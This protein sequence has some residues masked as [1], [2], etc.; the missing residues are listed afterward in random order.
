MLPYGPSI[1]A[2]RGETVFKNEKVTTLRI[3]AALIA[4]SAL[5]ASAAGIAFPGIYKPILPDHEVPFAF[6]QDI[7]SI[8]SAV[9]LLFTGTKRSA[10]FDIFRIGIIGYLFYAYGM[11]TI[12]MLYNY[13]YFLYLAVFGLSIFYFIIA[14]TGI[15]YDSLKFGMPSLL[16]IVIAI[17]CAFIAVFFA[18][19]WVVELSHIIQTNSR[20]AVFSFTPS[21]YILDLCFVLP[22]CAL[23][24]IFLFRKKVLGFALGGAISI[25]GFTLM[26]SVAAGFF[27]QPLFQQNMSVSD[28]VEFSA[29][30]AVFLVLSVFYFAYTKAERRHPL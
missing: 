22:V 6:G 16:R 25:K 10:K 1:G 2:K 12:G 11:Y 3:L 18:P 9:L 8:A 26:L 30:T 29:L 27:C 17:Y 20:P 5:V 21:V 24:S 13:F 14:F 19:Q 7:I 28:A 15:E 4:L 23:A